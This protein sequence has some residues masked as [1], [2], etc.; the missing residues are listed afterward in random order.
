M[1]VNI[2]HSKGVRKKNVEFLEEKLIH[3]GKIFLVG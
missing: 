3:K 2:W 1:V